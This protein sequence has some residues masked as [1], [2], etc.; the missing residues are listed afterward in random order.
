MPTQL[1][2][3]RLRQAPSERRM[4]GNVRDRPFRSPQSGNTRETGRG[5]QPGEGLPKTLTTNSDRQTVP[6]TVTPWVSGSPLLSSLQA[7][8]ASSTQA[9]LLPLT[10]RLEGV[11]KGPRWLD[12]QHPG[13]YSLPQ[14]PAPPTSGAAAAPS[15]RRASSLRMRRPAPQPPSRRELRLRRRWRRRRAFREACFPS[16]SAA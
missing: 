14:C 13:A 5:A 4:N 8:Q 1:W 10:P 9:L 16:S 15:Q 11:V 6:R 7:A 12:L 3:L 2:H